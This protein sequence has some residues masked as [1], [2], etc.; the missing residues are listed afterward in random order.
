M[1]KRTKKR[2]NL[3]L[4][5]VLSFV[6]A[7]TRDLV[8]K[9]ISIGGAF[10]ETSEPIPEGTEVFLS[11]FPLQHPGDRPDQQMVEFL[12][13]EVKRS[14]DQ[15]IAIEFDKLHHFEGVDLVSQH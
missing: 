13:G 12:K 5:A 8:T 9:D 4:R 6:D 14:N 11:L 3:S 15:G 1:E 10:F 7:P 2:Y